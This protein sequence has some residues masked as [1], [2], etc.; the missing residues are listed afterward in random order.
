MYLI[1]NLVPFQYHHQQLGQYS[2]FEF[3]LDLVIGILVYLT[4]SYTRS[5]IILQCTFLKCRRKQVLDIIGTDISFFD[6]AENT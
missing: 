3:P 1:V 4:N 2:L 6:L 5:I